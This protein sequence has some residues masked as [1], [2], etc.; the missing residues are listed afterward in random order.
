MGSAAIFGPAIETYK[1][2]LTKAFVQQ[3]HGFVSGQ[4]VTFDYKNLLWKLAE[5]TDTYSFPVLH[6]E[7]KDKFILGISGYLKKFPIQIQTGKEYFISKTKPGEITTRFNGKSPVLVCIESP[8]C[9]L[10]NGNVLINTSSEESYIGEIKLFSGDI[11]NNFLEMN[12]S[13]HKKED[14]PRL[15]NIFRSSF[16]NITLNHINKDQKTIRITYPCSSA[17]GFEVGQKLTV[18]TGRDIIECQILEFNKI[19]DNNQLYMI[20]EVIKCERRNVLEDWTP[21]DINDDIPYEWIEAK[22]FSRDCY[23]FW[24]KYD[25][26]LLP[27]KYDKHGTYGVRYQ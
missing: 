21:E 24:D 25:S 12:G 7:S 6:T 23:I 8:S 22:P 19:S 14:Y 10:L 1:E 9:I 16:Q 27:C 26:F 15:F 4:Y 20:L 11:P 3:D 18:T 13:I 17:T 5:Y 2:C